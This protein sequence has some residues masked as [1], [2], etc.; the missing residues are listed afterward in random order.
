MP[1]LT[2]LSRYGLLQTTAYP[3][4]S[5][6][7]GLVSQWMDTRMAKKTARRVCARA[8]LMANHG[9]L[10]LHTLLAP[11]VLLQQMHTNLSQL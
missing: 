5:F 11:D 7:K 10:Q 6:E 4:T 2:V 1:C 9:N 3:A 8:D